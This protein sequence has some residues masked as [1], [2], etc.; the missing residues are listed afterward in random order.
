MRFSLLVVLAACSHPPPPAPPTH[1]LPPVAPK[2]VALYSAEVEAQRAGCEA[3]DAWECVRFAIAKQSG[4][5]APIDLP[6]AAILFQRGCDAEIPEACALLMHLYQG[7][8]EGVARD[9]E[10]AAALRQRVCDLGHETY[11]PPPPVEDEE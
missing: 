11:C 8:G 1:T 4:D 2:P 5:G 7:G 9:P 3:G 6:G 10:K